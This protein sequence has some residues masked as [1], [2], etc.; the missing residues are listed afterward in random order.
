MTN[1][2][3]YQSLPSKRTAFGWSDAI[4]DFIG[5]HS[6]LVFGL[7]AV[8]WFVI[9]TFAKPAMWV[10]WLFCSPIIA[11]VTIPVLLLLAAFEWLLWGI[12]KFV[13]IICSRNRLKH[14]DWRFNLEYVLSLLLFLSPF[15]LI[16]LACGRQDEA[17]S[18][19]RINDWD[20]VD[21]PGSSVYVCTGGSAKR[22]H[23][24]KNCMGLSRCS[25]EVEG[26]SVSEATAAG[27]SPCKMCAE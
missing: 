7:L 11:W 20:E 22:Y 8:I 21:D 23:L 3:F 4:A 27:K 18:K 13:N 1:Y 15:L 9:L 5:N 17:H 14:I 19:V 16:P 2:R 12:S 24:D 10:T 26:M 6:W 25:G